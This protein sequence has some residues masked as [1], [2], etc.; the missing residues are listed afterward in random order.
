M[1]RLPLIALCALLIG[2]AP[3]ADIV[4]RGGTIYD[5]GTGQPIT[6]D[7]EIKGDRIVYVGRS[8]GTRAAQIVDA[9]GAIVAP[10]FIVSAPV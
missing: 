3:A 2:A 4:I 1:T 5:G 8:R 10:G 6:G 7:V 9:R